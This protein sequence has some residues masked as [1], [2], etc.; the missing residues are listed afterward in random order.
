MVCPGYTAGVALNPDLTKVETFAGGNDQLHFDNFVKAVR[1]RDSKLLNGDIEQGH[2][3]SALCHLGNISYRLG[4]EKPLAEAKDISQSKDAR[5]AFARMLEHLKAHDV[6]PATAKG[7]SGPLLT[8]DGEVFTGDLK[9]K[10]NAMLT[11]EYR[12]GFEVPA[13]I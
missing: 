5:E 10:A 1:A 3:S 6:D 9:D 7:R 4:D 2:L 13:K 8:L 12:K 11:R